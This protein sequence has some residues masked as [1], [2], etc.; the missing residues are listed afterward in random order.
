MTFKEGGQTPYLNTNI[1][2]RTEVTPQA[3]AGV[4][5]YVDRGP[6]YIAVAHFVDREYMQISA[7][8]F[9][10]LVEE[11][12]RFGK[13]ELDSI[14]YYTRVPRVILAAEEFVTTGKNR[15][16]ELISEDMEDEEYVG[17]I[18]Q[19]SEVSIEEAK[20]VLE[21]QSTVLEVTLGVYYGMI[22]KLLT[23]ERV[24]EA[25]KIIIDHELPMLEGSER[26]RDKE[27]VRHGGE[28]FIQVH[29]HIVASS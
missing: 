5:K 20:G 29:N 24:E 9:N 15:Y 14:P 1:P 22:H 28:R 6:L 12:V 19:E 23:E 18:A 17:R 2:W 13:S 26:D 25:V 27:A 16:L 3:V 7:E 8:V 4:N 21:D 10:L 11:G